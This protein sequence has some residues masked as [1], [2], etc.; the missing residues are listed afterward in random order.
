MVGGRRYIAHGT[1]F[2]LQALICTNNPETHPFITEKER[3]YLQ[4]ELG[5]LKRRTDLP[6]TPWRAIL[7]SVPMVALIFA[8]VGHNWG[9]FI[10]IN[11]L[12]K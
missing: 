3:N 9:L 8:Q 1:H 6:P 12:P 10:V 4:R 11:D 2:H 7:T 5:E